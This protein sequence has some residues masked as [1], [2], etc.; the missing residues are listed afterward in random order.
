[1]ADL[2]NQVDYTSRD[3]S[4]IRA[5]LIGNIGKFAP[6]W[7]SRDS[8]DIGIVLLELFAYM[9]DNLSFYIDRAAN[10]SFLSTATQRSSILALA[11]ML[12]YTPDLGV[13]ASAELTF[14]NPTTSPIYLAPGTKVATTMIM[15][16]ASTPATFETVAEGVTTVPATGS[17]TL[18]ARE[19]TSIPYEEV[20]YS[21][22]GAPNQ[23]FKLA[24]SNVEVYSIRVWV[25]GKEYTRVQH[26]IDADGSAPV[27]GTQ[28]DSEGWAY[29]EFGDNSGGRIPP[30]GSS[31]TVSY[32][33]T[34]GAA[35]NVP[36][37]TITYI[38]SPYYSDVSCTT[39]TAGLRVTNSDSAYGGT[40]PESTDSIRVNAP[41]NLRAINRAVT[42]R[43]YSDIASSVVGVGKT[44]AEALV[45]SNVILYMGLHS[46]S[47]L[48][49]EGNPTDTW[50]EAKALVE[51]ELSGK[52]PPGTSVTVVPP[53]MV[54][55]NVEVDV[56]V[57]D[58]YKQ[59]VVKT[60]VVNAIA[61]VLDYDYVGFG[62]LVT[63]Q[64]LLMAIGMVEGV[65]HAT[66]SVL[67]KTSTGLGNVQCEA[68]EIPYLASNPTVSLTGGINI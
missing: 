40:D 46:F 66:L 10:E 27:F 65:V 44:N 67:S 53:T 5:D 56:Q 55:I 19:G 57:A 24:Q 9:G 37:G 34:S 49:A 11:Q 29:I 26:L 17:V 12:G 48:D 7:T 41:R 35:G 16:G 33:S 23:V 28:V 42:T 25:D 30:T 64:E 43:D 32:R 8:N 14:T 52:T 21:F 15:N 39:E 60:D 2:V 3:Y 47:G 6:Q 58:S 13:S 62:K 20:S 51:Q 59:S 50:T 38:V 54:G 61:E 45:Y 22:D 1:M 36:A 31:I 63:Q 18:T 68:G 4:A